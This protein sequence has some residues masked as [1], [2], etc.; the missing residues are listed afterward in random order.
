M[1]I[2]IHRICQVKELGI[3]LCF[4][5]LCQSV[6]ESHVRDLPA[7]F[8]TLYGG[9]MVDTEAQNIFRRS[10]VLCEGIMFKLVDSYAMNVAFFCLEEFS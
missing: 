1:E 5:R 7:P 2:D 9:H 6:K 8:S 10:C 3:S 4:L